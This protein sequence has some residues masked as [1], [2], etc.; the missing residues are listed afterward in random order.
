M[1]REKLIR[2]LNMMGDL[3]DCHLEMNLNVVEMVNG[4]I[5]TCF[6][7]M[8]KDLVKLYQAY[9]DAMISLLGE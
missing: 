1:D 2:S 6:L 5:N 8:Y 4:V 3:I 7:M 9:N